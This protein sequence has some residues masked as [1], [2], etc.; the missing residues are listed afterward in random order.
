M[1]ACACMC[2][3][4]RATNGSQVLRKQAIYRSDV[5][6]LVHTCP[7]KSEANDLCQH[8]PVT[9]PGDKPYLRLI[10][11]A[12][13]E[14]TVVG[15]WPG[16]EPSL[17]WEYNEQ[18]LW[19]YIWFTQIWGTASTSNHV[20]WSWLYWILVLATGICNDTQTSRGINY[21]KVTY[22]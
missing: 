18:V 1:H 21:H 11:R 2:D 17:V 6:D 19:G 22:S 20:H 13:W 3:C 7:H 12:A 10:P 16:N 4:V 14:H 8:I 5:H 15:V 9:R